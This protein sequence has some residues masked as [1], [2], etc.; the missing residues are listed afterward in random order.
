MTEWVVSLLV[1]NLS[2]LLS[3]HFDNDIEGSCT[4]T[5]IWKT[6]NNI[7]VQQTQKN[8]NSAATKTVFCSFKIP[9]WLFESPDSESD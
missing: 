1:V 5:K 4:K 3:W 2:W 9:F 7:N 6:N 8:S